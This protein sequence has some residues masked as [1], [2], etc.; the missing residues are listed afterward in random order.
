[1]STDLVIPIADAVV[2]EL[3]DHAFTLPFMAVR[4]YRPRLSVKTDLDAPRVTVVPRGCVETALGRALV[5][6][7]VSVD[8]AVQRKLDRWDDGAADEAAPLLGLVEEIRAFFRLRR[9][10]LFPD[11]LW[12]EAVNQPL[13]SEAHMNELGVFTSVVTLTYRVVLTSP[14]A[15]GGAA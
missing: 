3:N 12:I 6:F 14:S 9:L 7:D 1:M 10:A 2:H 4:R 15:S 11:A 5:Q 8:V 13:W